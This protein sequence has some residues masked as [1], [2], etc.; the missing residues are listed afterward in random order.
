MDHTFLYCADSLRDP[1]C[2]TCRKKCRKCDRTRPHCMRCISKGLV[3]EGYPLNIKMYNQPSGPS[4]KK[5]SKARQSRANEISS[6]TVIEST[7]PL[8]EANDSPGGS[9]TGLEGPMV[10]LK[11]PQD[12]PTAEASSPS[13]IS[14]S[15]EDHLLKHCTSLFICASAPYLPGLIDENTL[16]TK[17]SITS[18]DAPNP[19]E[20]Y[21]LPLAY[22][23]IGLK[24]AIL[25]LSACHIAAQDEQA[26]KSMTTSAIQY[27]LA[28]IQSLSSLL[29]KEECF[30]LTEFEE[31]IALAIVLVLVLHDVSYLRQNLFF[32]VALV[33]TQ[34]GM[35]L[36]QVAARC[37]FE[38]S[39]VSLLS[40]RQSTACSGP[41]S[42]VPHHCIDVA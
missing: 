11:M 25:G 17:L 36:W 41:T 7:P 27:R 32:F 21:I 29:L 18:I 35:R 23:H 12:D 30:G 1:V 15:L 13:S 14:S 31:E 16:C 20:A 37:T 22:Q 26:Q 28:A 39:S 33:D 2:G 24:K 34:A 19:F 38:R 42:T 10:A 9:A 3:C 5:R 8:S 6:K 4:P 40:H